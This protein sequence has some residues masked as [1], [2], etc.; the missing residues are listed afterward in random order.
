MLGW[1][2]SSL[3]KNKQQPQR[4]LS[5]ILASGAETLGVQAILEP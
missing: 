3:I 1:R 2:H 4:K 5:R